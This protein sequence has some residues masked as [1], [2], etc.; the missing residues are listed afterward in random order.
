MS[1]TMLRGVAICVLQIAIMPTWTSAARPAQEP[2]QAPAAQT[3]TAP[4]PAS[5]EP[6]Y[7]IGIE[8]VL[9]I[10]V[11]RDADLTQLVPVRP[12]GSISLPLIQDVRAAGRT[13]ED[14]ASDIRRRLREFMTNPAVTVVV[15]EVNSLK[16]FVL[17]EVVRPGPVVLRSRTSLL[18]AIAQAGG[19]TPFGGRDGVIIYRQ[20][21]GTDRVLEVSYRDLVSGRRPEGNVPLE[22]GDTVLVR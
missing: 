21:S 14:L 6:T 13:P 12:D 16:V 18:Q 11:W 19:V 4:A 15:R 10:S 22:P 8:D 7:R 9:L 20:G 2:D 3:A 1:F 5:T 17:G